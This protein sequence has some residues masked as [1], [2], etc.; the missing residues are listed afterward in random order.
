MYHTVD[1]V[2]HRT[3]LQLRQIDEIV[4]SRFLPAEKVKAKGQFKQMHIRI[5]ILVYF[6][7]M[8][9]YLPG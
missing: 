8:L 9:A 6:L 5:N 1:I 7:Y 3:E 2:W 4:I